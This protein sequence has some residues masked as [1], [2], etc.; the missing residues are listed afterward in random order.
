MFDEPEIWRDIRNFPGYQISSEGRVKDPSGDYIPL[1][2]KNSTADLHV[3]F[4]Y[5]NYSYQGPVWR[6]M[7]MSFF[8][9][10]LSEWKEVSCDYRDNNKSNLDIFNLTFWN[11]E[12]IPYMFTRLP[13]GDWRRVRRYAKKV[14]VVE[15][16]DIYES[17]RDCA[18][19]LN[20]TLDSVYKTLRGNLKTLHG[21]HLEYVSD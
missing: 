5:F 7:L 11:S 6:L 9:F 14:R 18:E 1:T 3:H 20:S 16:G 12:G 21:L 4:S 19:S 13:S 10:N 17:A 8:E 2:K 15:T